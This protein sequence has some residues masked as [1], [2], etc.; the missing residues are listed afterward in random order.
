MT[1][2]PA[3]TLCPGCFEAAATAAPC[4]VCGY[5]P[6]APRPPT[7]L[8]PGVLLNGQF[9]IGRLLGKPG[10]FGLTYLGFDCRLHARVA[11]KEYLPRDL[12]ARAT[13]GASILPHGTDDDA[14]FRFGLGQFEQEAQTL[15]RLDHPNIVRV[16][17]Y[18]EANASAYLVMDYYQGITLAEYLERQPGGRLPADTALALLQPV[19][20]GLRAVHAKGLLHRDIKPANIYL[21][22]TDTGGARPILL[23]FGAARQAVGERS[24]SLSVM[25]TEG[26]APFEQY[27]RKGHQGPWTD[28]YGAAAVL[29][30]SVTGETPPAAND[31]MLG[32]DL[33]PASDFAVPA[34]TSAALAA[35]LALRPEARPQTVDAFRAL[36]GTRPQPIPPPPVVVGQ[37]PVPPSPPKPAIRPDRR[38]RRAP[39]PTAPDRSWMV[40]VL[41]VLGVGAGGY[42]WWQYA[43]GQRRVGVET[44]LEAARQVE[45]AR[46]AREQAD[47]ER[48]EQEQAERERLARAAEAQRQADAAAEAARQAEAARLAR[49]QANRERQA[50]AERER[51]ARAAEAQRQ[52]EAEVAE[53]ER[54]AEVERRVLEQAEAAG[55]RFVKIAADGRVLPASA[56]T[57]ACVRDTSTGLIWELKTADGGLRDQAHTYTWYDPNPHTNGGDPGFQGGGSCDGGARCDT[58][59]YVEAVNRV[60]LCGAR[61]WR[62]PRHNEL[63]SIAV[64]GRRPTIDTDWFPEPRA[65]GFGLGSGSLWYW[66]GSS[67][68]PDSTRSYT[69]RFDICEEWSSDRA[70]AFQVRLVRRV[71]P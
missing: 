33:R 40:P 14:L 31:R 13:D 42:G 4:P 29:Y 35:G 43:E 66:T 7:A 25:L 52:L 2:V 27:S 70:T 5:D 44:A 10:G 64:C 45:T 30:R 23:D 50:Q 24:R 68:Y 11:I 41:V 36:L 46:L 53:A 58:S 16:R 1:D 12:A 61:D 8:A 39:A 9:V 3:D 63:E 32:D 28:V 65:A 15:A 49:E 54:Q 6:A 37:A 57:W 47:R 56:T 69:R 51:L 62:M 20:D 60:G 26:Y 38:P 67:A 21:A 48:Q 55:Q 19:L 18:F 17:Q 34:A 71:S 59:G 22:Q